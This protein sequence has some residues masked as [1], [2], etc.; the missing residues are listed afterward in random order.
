MIKMV[1]LRWNPVLKE[2][3]II[4]GHRTNRPNLPS[5]DKCPFCSNADELK[6]LGEWNYI[7]LPNKFPSLSKDPPK[8]DLE[9]DELFKVAPALGECEVVLYTPE[10]DTKLEHLSIDHIIGL[11]SYWAKRYKEIGEKKEINYVLIFE[12]RGRDV[13]VSLDHPHGQIYS[14]SFIPSKLKRELNASS[15]FFEKNNKCLFCTILDKEQEF[16]KR[17]IIEN[18]SFTCFIPFFATWPYGPHIYPKKHLQNINELSQSEKKDLASILKLI[19]IKLNNLFHGKHSFEMIFH[20][21]PTDGNDYNYY[22][23]H[24]E[25]Y[26]INR[27]IDKIKYLGGCELGGGTFINSISPEDAAE[28]LRNS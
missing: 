25:F 17:I 16:K 1:E 12:N 6:N 26:V 11:I 22:H 4:A 28:S 23:F 21:E 24:I 15:E 2:W 19:L 5:K 7:S 9:G 18:D 10:H 27:A 8:P 13:G 20:Q 3:I 14:F